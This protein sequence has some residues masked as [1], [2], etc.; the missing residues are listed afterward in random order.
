MLVRHPAARLA[1]ALA[2]LST[3]LCAAPRPRRRR[4]KPPLTTIMYIVN[5]PDSIASFAAHAGEVSIAAPQSFV[6]DAAGFVG[7]NIPDEVLAVARAR[8]VALMPLV[9]NRG[10]SQPLMRTLLDSRASRARAIRY[11]IYLARRDGD[12]GFQFDLE[13]I[14][15]TYRRQYTEFFR[16]AAIAFHR[17]HLILSAA[18]VGR[19]PGESVRSGPSGGFA[20]WGGVYNYRGIARWANFLTLMAYPQHGGFSG[21][22]AVAGY[23]W[24]HRMLAYARARIPARKLSLGVPTYGEEWTPRAQLRPAAGDGHEP[25]GPAPAGWVVH[26]VSFSDVAALLAGPD[27]GGEAVTRHW[28]PASRSHYLLVPTADG[29]GQVWY[30]DAASLRQE[31]RLMRRY[32]VRSI[33]AWRLGGEDPGIWPLLRREFRI[34][35]PRPPRLA[36]SFNQRSRAAAR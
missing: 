35:H 30:A 20:N 18:V 5:Q 29:A 15:Y 9:T 19:L 28:D 21:P 23:E 34:R 8:H 7:G 10:F 16:E 33:S 13:H 27:P 26:G 2:I 36:G 4:W 6:L 3:A 17:H 24:V 11:L 14:Y 32:G 25:P 31:L 22:G 12:I 1:L